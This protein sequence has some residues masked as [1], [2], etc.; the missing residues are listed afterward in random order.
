MPH[1]VREHLEAWLSLNRD[2]LWKVMNH[3]EK[4]D[5]VFRDRSV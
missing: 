2:F 5:A 1:D 4:V 3:K